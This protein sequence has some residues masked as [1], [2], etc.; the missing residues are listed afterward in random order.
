MEWSE[1]RFRHL[2]D[3]LQELRQA[4][5]AAERANRAKSDFLSHMS[6][7]IRTPM[8]GVLGMAE[9]LLETPLSAVQRRYAEGAKEAATA[10][11]GVIDEILDLAKI[12]AGHVE[13]ESIPFSLSEILRSLF[14]TL[15]LPAHQKG[16]DLISSVD[17]DVP[18]RLVGDPTRVRQVLVNLLGNA[19]KFTAAG[20]VI[21]RV[22]KEGET[23]DHFR[24]RFSVTDTGIGLTAE[25]RQRIFEPF[26]QAETG[27]SRRYGGTGLGLPISA[28]LA[29]M[30]NGRLDVESEPGKGSS[31]H[32]IAEL[33]RVPRTYRTKANPSPLQGVRIAVAEHHPEQRRVLGEILASW[34]MAAILVEDAPQ[35]LAALRQGVAQG[36][37]FR[38]VLLDG[39][40]PGVS[41]FAVAE[42]L[43]NDPAL[44]AT[45]IIFMLNFN[46]LPA[47]ALP[48]LTSGDL[49][50]KIYLTKPVA[51]SDL[52]QALLN[53]TAPV[54]GAAAGTLTVR[55]PPEEP[56]PSRALRVLL[57]EDNYINQVV[58]VA[59]LES[60]GHQVVVAG[61]GEEAVARFR[62][63]IFDVLLMDVQM[64]AMDGLEATRKIRAIEGQRGAGH[65]PII[66]MTAQALS[67]DREDCMAAGM[68]DYL[69]KPI[70][71]ENLG[72]V[73]GRLHGLSPAG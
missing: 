37:P 25:Q 11:L 18:D 38:Y 52:Q 10:L 8:N 48:S 2:L 62:D 41:G 27:T 14:K 34:G 15:A 68:D 63:E 17:P 36:D 54:E 6:H 30:M 4:K 16:L 67:G 35:V 57:A 56:P 39:H 12:E 9:L 23:G 71:A 32:F 66:A 20:S 70:Q 28:H 72:A 19:I 47:E 29:Q 61:D 7:E 46:E 40:L 58:A 55:P 44:A 1:A 13:L 50:V 45:Q 31:F 59:Q 22:A 73:L 5:E 49:R 43:R 33:D 51:P 26:A 24:L 21:L 3:T 69:T 65:V 60:F 53:A 64:P 42:V